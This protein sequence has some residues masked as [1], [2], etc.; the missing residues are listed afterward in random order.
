MSTT[1]EEIAEE[2]A[3]LAQEDAEDLQD[4]GASPISSLV[5]RHIENQATAKRLGVHRPL[6]EQGNAERLLDLFGS[7]IRFDHTS[8]RWLL[9]DGRRWAPDESGQIG[10]LVKMTLRSIYSEASSVESAEE[11][12]AIAKWAM[13][14]ESAKISDAV[15][16]LA[17]SEPT[18]A[19]TAEQ[20]D[21]DQMALNVLNGTLDLCTCT[22]RP[23]R[24]PDLISKIARVKYDPHAT[25]PRWETFISEIMPDPEIRGFAQT[26]AGYCLSGDVSE[27]VFP[28]A[29]GGGQ[30]G[31]TV[32]FE[33]LRDMLADYAGEVSPD[34]L[35]VSKY[36]DGGKVATPQ[37]AG[38]AGKRII[39]SSESA[40]GAR[41]DDALI[42]LYTGGERIMARFLHGNPFAFQPTAKIVLFTNHRPQIPASDLGIWRRIRLIPFTVTIP[43]ENRDMRLR[44]RLREEWPGILNW[45]LAG[46]ARWRALGL[47]TTTTIMEAT[48]NYRAA[49]DVLG[50]W[51]ESECFKDPYA[52]ARSSAL[53]SFYQKWCDGENEQTMTSRS[54]KAALEERGFKS[55]HD[56]SGSYFL[57]INIRQNGTKNDTNNDR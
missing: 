8:R 52:R 15:L 23:H 26:L 13:R 27:Q 43:E 1:I 10:F 42:K 36:M 51:I 44:E 16:K 29:F 45:C 33:T 56:S 40:A 38:T 20:L 9:W 37:I 46:F 54:F 2:A 17:P 41:L 12:E 31:K 5:H 3:K 21:G 32:F 19:L 48:R 6:T 18:I 53:F 39:L 4:R 30:N 28:I 50:A 34:V 11:R 47:Q 49:E 14:S 35:M 7:D 24:Q 25:A 57:G 55:G 22:L